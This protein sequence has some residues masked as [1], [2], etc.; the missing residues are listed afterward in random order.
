MEM[1]V[2]HSVSQIDFIYE[3]D[4]IGEHSTID[5][6]IVPENLFVEI[7]LYTC[8]QDEDNPSDHYP[9][10]LHLSVIIKW[11]PKG[12]AQNCVPLSQVGWESASVADRVAYQ[13]G[14]DASSAGTVPPNDVLNWHNMKCQS[15]TSWKSRNS[16]LL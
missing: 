2:N 3:N 12:P 9:P 15:H 13:Q 8:V 5:H 6:F 1:C 14:L 11:A 4:C 10:L 16:Y 7:Q